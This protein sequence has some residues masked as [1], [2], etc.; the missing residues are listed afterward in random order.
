MHEYAIPSMR[1]NPYLIAIDVETNDL[2]SINSPNDIAQE[3]I[4]LGMKLKSDENDIM[5]SGIIA[6]KDDKLLEDKGRKVNVLLKIKTSELGFGFIEHNEIEPQL[7]CNYG[8]LHRNFDGTYILG[9]NF[10]KMINA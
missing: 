3:I 5:T 2:R 10:V 6:R 9:S 1:H 7:H 8:G 4:E